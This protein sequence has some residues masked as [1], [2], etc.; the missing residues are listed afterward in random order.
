MS[1][2]LSFRLLASPGGMDDGTPV[3][4]T[5]FGVDVNGRYYIQILNSQYTKF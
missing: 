3:Q 4:V 1:A 5:L 2:N